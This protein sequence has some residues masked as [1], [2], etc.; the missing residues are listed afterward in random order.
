MSYK[1]NSHS[2]SNWYI[3]NIPILHSFHQKIKD[4]NLILI[5]ITITFIK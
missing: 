5:A 2:D 1:E 3:P 4:T